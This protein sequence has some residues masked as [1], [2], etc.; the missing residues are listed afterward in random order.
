MSVPKHN[1]ILETVYVR[2][3]CIL[4]DFYI[5]NF[6]TKSD[7]NYASIK[8]SGSITSE[9]FCVNVEVEGEGKQADREFVKSVMVFGP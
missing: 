3:S 6:G 5:F 2:R 1:D 4:H 7:H 8:D 9:Q